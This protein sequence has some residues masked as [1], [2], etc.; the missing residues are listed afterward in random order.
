[1][2]FAKTMPVKGH[3]GQSKTAPVKSHEAVNDIYRTAAAGGYFP[4]VLAVKEDGVLQTKPLPLKSH[5]GLQILARSSSH[6]NC[7]SPSREDVFLDNYARR[8]KQ[9]NEQGYNSVNYKPYQ[10]L[11]GPVVLDEKQL[12]LSAL[13]QSK[14]DN[15]SASESKG[16]SSEKQD[17]GKKDGKGGNG[18]EESADAVKPYKFV[19]RRNSK[20]HKS[21]HKEVSTGR[22]MVKWAKLGHGVFTMIREQEELRVNAEHNERRRKEEQ[23]KKEWQPAVVEVSDEGET[24]EELEKEESLSVYMNQGA[25]SRKEVSF[26]FDAASTVPDNQTE[27]GDTTRLS[28]TAMMTTAMATTPSKSIL[29]GASSPTKRRRNKRLVE[30]PR[31]YTPCHTNINIDPDGD[32]TDKKAIFRQMCAVNWILEAMMIEPPAAMEPISK[33]W[34]IKY[35]DMENRSYCKTTVQRLRKEKALDTRW[36]AFISAEGAGHLA[37]LPSLLQKSRSPARGLLSTQN[38]GFSRTLRRLSA[39]STANRA[40]SAMGQSSVDQSP[41]SPKAEDTASSFLEAA[42]KLAEIPDS[43][44]IQGGETP[45]KLHRSPSVL[46]ERTATPSSKRSGSVVNKL[47]K[48]DLEEKD[49]QERPRERQVST[50]VASTNR[51]LHRSQS[52]PIR[53]QEFKPIFPS[54]KHL[55]LAK[56]LR[57]QFA[58][59]TED[60]ALMLHDKLEAMEKKRLERSENK[61][62]S[63]RTN[64][65]ISSQLALLKEAGQDK[66][67]L[68]AEENKRKKK[69]ED[70]SKWYQELVRNLPADI[71]N[72]RP[73]MAI[74]DKL[75]SLGKIESRKAT[76]QKFLNVLAGLRH[77]EICSPDISAAIEF[78]R[79]KVVGMA[80]EEFEAWYQAEMPN[81]ARSKSAPPAT[82]S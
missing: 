16:V 20:N 69:L 72:D 54:R 3:Y 24:D 4:G 8:T 82:T 11:G 44:S 37:G 29:S 66:D 18:E 75:Q 38:S 51:K 71:N 7:A 36:N 58:D 42:D 59:V 81:I 12:I 79:E 35:R 17:E 48:Q 23:R 5:Q 65:H 10:L 39:N 68:L 73:C 33:C 9:L 26:A 31:P 60:Q 55:Y 61:F 41:L 70:E 34:K 27:Q 19:V 57:T 67:E 53:N 80:V 40:A 45:G 21:L 52:A 62:Q 46:S 14:R 78:V 22:V 1:M 30:P 63:I 13:G 74:L 77:W 56:E 6:Y 49:K 2:V 47:S 15:Y 25:E 32:E 28:T 50:W 43:V 64:V 76:P